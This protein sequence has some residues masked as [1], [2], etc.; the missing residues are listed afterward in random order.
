MKKGKRRNI[1]IGAA[2]LTASM[3]IASAAIATAV[4]QARGAEDSERCEKDDGLFVIGFPK[5]GKATPSDGG[6]AVDAFFHLSAY[7][8]DDFLFSVSPDGMFAKSYVRNAASKA[9]VYIAHLSGDISYQVAG[10]GAEDFCFVNIQAIFD[11]YG[12]KSA[13]SVAPSLRKFYAVMG[14]ATP[15]DLRYSLQLYEREFNPQLVDLPTARPRPIMSSAP[16]CFMDSAPEG[17]DAEKWGS[18]YL[19]HNLFSLDFTGEEGDMPT[20]SKAWAISTCASVVRIET[21]SKE[22]S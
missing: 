16:I 21:M 12:G 20:I 2:M 10:E 11:K 15:Y 18:R 14:S 6:E 1:I 19:S 3:A 9:A 22:E 17:F 7:Y 13:G 4:I 5:E 8:G